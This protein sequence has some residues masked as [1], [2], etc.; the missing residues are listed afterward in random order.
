MLR[1]GSLAG[2]R[3]GVNSFEREEGF[4]EMLKKQEGDEKEI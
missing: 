1:N 3:K 2:R 4:G